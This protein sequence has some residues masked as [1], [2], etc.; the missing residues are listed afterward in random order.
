LVMVLSYRHAFHAGSASDV[1]KHVGLLQL[2]KCLGS[3]GFPTLYIDS[4]SGAG[5]YKLQ[6]KYSQQCREFKQGIYRMVSNQDSF[7]KDSL[8]QE[9]MGVVSKFNSGRTNKI[10][11]YPG[12]VFFGT[13]YF[14]Q[15]DCA[16]LFELHPKDAIFLKRDMHRSK[17]APT[18]PTKV[19]QQDGMEGLKNYFETQGQVLGFVDPS[20]EIETDYGNI[21]GKVLDLCKDGWFKPSFGGENYHTLMIWYPMLAGRHEWKKLRKN[22]DIVAQVS[23]I[24]SA[25]FEMEFCIPVEN[26]LYGSGL[27]VLNAPPTLADSLGAPYTQLSK[28]LQAYYTEPGKL[29]IL[30]I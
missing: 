15:E 5:T 23:K 13:E 20:Y 18:F 12:S 4:H 8:L 26:G 9:Y 1:M 6:H 25:G 11:R 3:T 10:R 28:V 22:L 19:F 17:W 2:A 14:G 7:A 29:N 21:L 30:K 16:L 27:F 24:P